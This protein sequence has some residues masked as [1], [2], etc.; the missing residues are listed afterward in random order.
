MK[1]AAITFASL[2][3]LVLV[4]YASSQP[5]AAGTQPVASG[6]LYAVEFKTGPAWDDNKKPHEQAYFREHSANLKR[7]RDQG[8]LI[9]GARYSDKGL[10]VLQASSEQDAHAM[11]QQDPSVRNKVFVYELDE[12]N[13][14]YSGFVQAHPRRE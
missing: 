13:V 6:S 1:S 10:V 5:Q 3:G 12:F 8:H 4:E 11:V 9:L 14:F 7:L 2:V